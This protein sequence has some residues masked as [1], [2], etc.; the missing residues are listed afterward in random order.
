MAKKARAIQVKV[1]MPRDLQ[2]LIERDAGRHGQT[3]NA[4]ILRRLESSYQSD[5]LLSGFLDKDGA[6]LLRIVA[7]TLLLAGNWREDQQLSKRARAALVA[8]LDYYFGPEVL[9]TTT[10]AD[11]KSGEALA[12]VAL[13]AAGMECPFSTGPFPADSAISW[14]SQ[15]YGLSRDRVIAALEEERKSAKSEKAK[16]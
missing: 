14:I 4:E 7:T 10:E 5:A 15:K 9:A 2:R 1:R 12:Q 3:I 13:A 8:A 11:E 16:K 6:A